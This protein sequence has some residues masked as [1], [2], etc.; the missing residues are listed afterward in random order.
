MSINTKRIFTGRNDAPESGSR[1]KEKQNHSVM[2]KGFVQVIEIAIAALLIVLVLPVFFSS[3]SA[4]QDWARHDLIVSGSGIVR[5]LEAGGNM[6]Q[7]LNNTQEIIRGIEALKPANVK[8]SIYAEGTPKPNIFL[9]CV[10][11]SDA[12][13]FYA[14]GVFTPAIFNGRLVNFTVEKFDL[15]SQP[16]IPGNF[17]AAVFID[18]SGWAAQKQKILYF[19]AQGKGIVAMQAASGDSDFLNMFN[20][21]VAGGSASYQNFTAYYPAGTNIEKYFLGFGF[22]ILTADDGTGT[23]R[24]IWN[25][26]DSRK[27]INTTG[28]NVGLEDYGIVLGEGGIFSLPATESPDGRTYS[29]RIKKIWADRSGVVV[30]SM[31][32]SFVFKDFLGAAES[33]VKGNSIL[34]GE[35]ATY[36][37]MAKNNSAIW[38]SSNKTFANGEYRAL[39]KAAAA[40]LA[41]SFYLVKP[42]NPKNSVNVNAFE[43]FCCDAP[44]TVKLTFLLWYVY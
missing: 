10:S 34:E 27:K 39:A 35:G 12:Q 30:Q 28:T 42:Q 44:E 9:A 22:D 15:G 29:F 26:W 33:K 23:Y 43:S 19:L 4:K 5:S 41:E 32:K 24:G 11:C 16:L 1:K 38:I 31:N 14:Q 17:D 7:I 18:Y 36:S 37:L 6:S 21:S 2:K 13:L 25:I 40:S 3:L 20:L 8:Y